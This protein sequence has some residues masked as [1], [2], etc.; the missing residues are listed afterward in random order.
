MAAALNSSAFRW[1]ITYDGQGF[2][3]DWAVTEPLKVLVG[4]ALCYVAVVAFAKAFAD[5]LKILLV[6]K[7]AHNLLLSLFSGVVSFVTSWMMLKEDHFRSLKAATCEPIQDERFQLISFIFLLSKIWEWFDTVLLIVKGKDVRF[8]HALHHMTT[9]WLYAVDHLFLSSIKYGVAVNAFIHAVMYA[10]YYRP[11]PRFR[12]VITQ[13]Q[14]I[15]FCFSIILH[16]LISVY[17]CDPKVHT[18]YTEYLTPYFLVV[19]YLLL[20]VHF[21][22]S[23][24]MNKKN[25]KTKRQ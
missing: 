22:I 10:H 17:D 7:D 9:F 20:F 25:G 12:H 23:E 1:E 6:L 19:P 18:N 3:G 24:Y 4:T 14:I 8:L 2:I 5:R 15:Q 16:T 21:Y 13:M 11:F